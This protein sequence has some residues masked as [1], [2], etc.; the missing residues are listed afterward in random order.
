MRILGCIVKSV[1]T[2]VVLAV[3]VVL[4]GAALPGSEIS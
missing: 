2:L 3:I 4:V 1:T